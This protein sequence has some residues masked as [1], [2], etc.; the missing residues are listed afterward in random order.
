[1]QIEVVRGLGYP[2]FSE[3]RA[4]HDVADTTLPVGWQDPDVSRETKRGEGA[5]A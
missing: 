2:R 1:M 4:P 3:K 5:R